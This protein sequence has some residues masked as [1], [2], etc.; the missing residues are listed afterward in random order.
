MKVSAKSVSVTLAVM[1]M[2]IG[3]TYFWQKNN[4]IPEFSARD[5]SSLLGDLPL[6]DYTGALT[7]NLDQDLEE[8]ILI[9]A[10]GA[11][12]ILLK[13]NK[14]KFISLNIPSL[15]SSEGHTVAVS[16]CDL[17]GDGRDEIFFLNR[18]EKSGVSHPQ[19]FTF[20]NGNWSDLLLHDPSLSPYTNKGTAVTCIDRNGNR[21][22]ELVIVSEKG[23]IG[24]FELRENKLVD[25]APEIGINASPDA[26]S[27]IGVPGPQGHTNIFVGTAAANLYFMNDGHG[28][29]GE[30]NKKSLIADAN[31]KTMGGSVIDLNHDDLPD[32]TYGNNFGPLRIWIQERSGNF[33][34][35]T[36]ENL[37]HSYAV[38]SVVA[39]DLNL[40]GLVDLYLNNVRGENILFAGVKKSWEKIS[41]PVLE[42]KEMFG[43]SSLIGDFDGVP[44]VEILNT[45][46][47]GKKFSPRLYSVAPLGKQFQV[48]LRFKN[49][50]VPR[51]AV[52]QVKT[53]VETYTRVVPN[54]SGRFANY[55]SDLILGLKQ[56]EKPYSVEVFLP[57]GEKKFFEILKDEAT[58]SAQI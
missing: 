26:F 21:H 13:P 41:A 42:E 28:K 49:G 4:P 51:G 31:F 40:D 58:F 18:S 37:Q 20:R 55:Q 5:V 3:G 48:R 11:P 15:E 52:V 53:S 44:G 39:A 29:Y 27:V 43:V 33:Q 1:I 7:V 45:H 19:L 32:L 35:K 8:E 12:N 36:P 47:D 25:V 14:N 34:D 24:V 10:I 30:G 38:N 16:A 57:S 22:Y 2:I 9:G 54:G 6:G 17:D 56:N 50:G 46:G 23:P